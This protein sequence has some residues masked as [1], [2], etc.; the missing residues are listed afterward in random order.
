VTGGAVA[1][2]ARSPVPEGQE[3]EDEVPPLRFG[4]RQPSSDD[5]GNEGVEGGSQHAQVGGGVVVI[6]ILGPLWVH[7]T[8]AWCCAHNSLHRGRT[9][10]S[11]QMRTRFCL[12]CCLCVGLLVC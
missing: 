11:M 8:E 10:G 2:P 9:A 1:V 4:G 5:T 7:A 6:S 3:G 12:C